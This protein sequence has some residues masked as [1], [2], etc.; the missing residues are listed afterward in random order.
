MAKDFL[1]V[2]SLLKCPY[3]ENAFGMQNFFN[4]V[5]ESPQPKKNQR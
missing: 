5:G 2:Q 1:E 4:E 3:G